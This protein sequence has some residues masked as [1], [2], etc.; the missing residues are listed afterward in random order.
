MNK[1]LLFATMSLAALAACTTDDF[2]SQKVAEEMSPVK[3]EIIN[4]NDALTRASMDGNAIVWN[5]NDGDLF[6]LYH[7][8]ADAPNYLTGYENAAYKAVANEGGATLS[9][10]TMIKEGRAIMVW[11]VDTTF[12]IGPGDALAISIPVEQTNIE[13]NIPYVSDLI[14]IGAY[15]SD[16]PYN[17]AGK[18]RKYPLYMRPMASQLTLKADYDGSDATIAELYDGGS[19]CPADGGIEPISL[20]SVELSAESGGL[21]PFS[22]RVPV[23]FSA[24]NAGWA[25]LTNNNA[26]EKVT[27]FDLTAQAAA[28][29]TY[30]LTSTCITGTESCKFLI[31]PQAQMTT[32]GQGVSE[33][34]VVVNTIYGKVVIQ[35]P[36][37]V[38][39]ET[40]YTAAEIADAWYRYVS[41]S[42]A[43]GDGE[44]K[45][46]TAGSDGKFKTTANIEMGMKQTINAF[47]TA[48]ASASN[49]YVGGEPMGAAATRY[50][51]V[52]LNYLDMSDL[53]IKNDKHL[54]DAAIV[55][56]HIGAGDVKVFLDGDATTGEFQISQQTIET[57]NEIN[58][59]A[60]L[61]ATPR[62]FEVMPCNVAGEVCNTIV[63]TGGGEVQNLTFLRRNTS[64]V[65][66]ADVVF[67]A[68]ETW[69]WNGKVKVL[70]GVNKGVNNFINR[71]TMQNAANATLNIFNKAN[72]VQQYDVALVNEGTWNITGGDLN[73]QFDV[74]NNGIVNIS[75]GAE[76][77]QDGNGVGTTF[78]NEASTLPE[79]FTGVAEEI[80]VINNSGVFATRNAGVINNYGLIEHAHENA[81]TYITSNETTG[82]DFGTA[83]ADPANKMGRINLPWDNKGEDNVSISATAA[84]GFVSVTVDGEV[85]TLGTTAGALG[86]YVNYIII[87]SG[88]TEIQ[89]LNAQYKYVEINQ[90][91]TEIAW[92]TGSTSNYTGLVVLSNVNI[93]LGTTVNVSGAS[94]LDANAKMYVGG[95]YNNTGSGWNGYYGNT[96]TNADA[97]YIT[98]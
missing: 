79:R 29:Y 1:K 91:G 81:K 17:T 46:A 67:N 15:D 4:G 25:T 86:N 3:F 78:T 28:D 51:K 13:N 62:T 45:A 42:T 96:T 76:Y 49:V 94:Y 88:V 95:T 53:H 54:R 11:P 60:A 64:P 74:I 39:S 97:N 93:T 71:G 83:F 69:N 59:A 16:A 5:A 80:G 82:A 44:T 19:A 63:I 47:G 33:A 56:N 37:V 92:R 85:S 43:A 98:Y 65:Q 40:Q 35:D 2:E 75:L 36:S 24:A 70:G 77:R 48:T 52:L 10:P 20:T 38:G 89:A 30:Q 41:A 7:G 8:S 32:P 66:K 58:A 26:W 57:I 18:D 84:N 14:N 50:V 23:K 9:T 27:D 90:P 21:T 72:A 73:V 87:K 68:G 31:L 34:A 6:T 12:N 55:W 22:K 61:E